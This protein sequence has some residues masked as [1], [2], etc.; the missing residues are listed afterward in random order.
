MG[1]YDVAVIGYGPTGMTLAALLGQHGH[2]VVVLERYTGLYNL[3]RAACFDDEIMRTF[4]KLGLAGEI[5][6]G[7]VV[8]RDYEWINAAGETLVELTYADPAPCGWAQLYMMFQPHVEDVLD[9]H[10]KALPSVAVHQGASVTALVQDADGV[11]LRGTREGG[12]DFSVRARFV[13]GADGGNG[14]TRGVVAEAADDYGFQENWLVCDFRMR[15]AVPG[16]PMFR[17]VCDPAQPTSIVRI[18]PDHHRFSF[19][20]NPGETREEATRSE[21]VWAR[22]ARYVAPDDAELIRAVNYV[23]RSRIADRWRRGR[24]FLAGDAAHEMPPF[25]AQGMCSGIRDSH[26]LAWKLDLVL[27]GR[28]DAALLDTYQQER[29]PHVRFITER[30]IEL[31]RV[32]TMRDPA[33]ARERD[34]RLLAQR[35]AKREPEKLRFPPLSGAL[36]ANNGGLFPQGAVSD[37]VRSGLVDDIVGTGWCIV[38]VGPRL[39]EALTADQRAAWEALGGRLAIIGAP[40]GLEDR[41]GIYA[42]WFAANG[43]A[44][45]VVRPDWYVYGTASDEEGLAALL[46]RVAR[47]LEGSDVLIPS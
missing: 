26:N 19:M 23:F 28:A 11:T 2:R 42:E 17:Q 34:E 1:E 30:A 29:E 15:R 43:C 32:Q 14:F 47:A 22:V 41:G 36:I 9:R 27:T 40:G 3:P 6:R 24:V 35:R 31:G 33:R 5:G 8:Q 45:A 13:V 21:R 37:G 38:A 10:D 7:A 44:V 12:G 20:L 39:I 18:G 46:Q 4:Q 16:L 25:L